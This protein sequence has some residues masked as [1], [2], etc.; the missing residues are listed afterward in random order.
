LKIQKKLTLPQLGGGHP[1]PRGLKVDTH[2]IFGQLAPCSVYV[3]RDFSE[4]L[5]KLLSNTPPSV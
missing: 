5:E 1:T 2:A 3:K 4:L